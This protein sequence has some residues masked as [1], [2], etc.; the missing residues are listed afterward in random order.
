VPVIV[1][2]DHV[3]IAAPEGCEDAARAFYGGL[4]GLVEIEK[5]APL[6]ARGGVWFRIG[7]S[8][9]LHI[10][11]VAPFAPAAK[12]HPGLAAADVASLEALAARIEN[13]GC[14]VGWADPE[15]IPGWR[16]FHVADPWGNRIELLA[17]S[18]NSA[19]SRHEVGTQT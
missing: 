16:R 1:G 11:V 3:Q 8:A 5:P 13:A 6:R 18:G 15:E 4:L 9:E 2:L 19:H 14:P 10:G 17:P 7:N 12:A